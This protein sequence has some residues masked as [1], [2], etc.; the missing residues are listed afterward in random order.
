VGVKKKFS[1]IDWVNRIEAE[2]KTMA[3]I[4]I[5]DITWMELYDKW[6]PLVPIQ[7]RQEFKFFAEDPGVERRGKVKAHSKASKK[8]C[9][10]RLRTADNG[11]NGGNAAVAEKKFSPDMAPKINIKINSCMLLL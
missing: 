10:E 8:Q 6:W 4:G 5:Q 1:D 11:K 9:A 2:L 7:H 3:P